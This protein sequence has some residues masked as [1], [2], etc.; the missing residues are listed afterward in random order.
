MN[1]RGYDDGLM[2][3][4]EAIPVHGTNLV[5]TRRYSPEV[6]TNANLENESEPLISSSKINHPGKSHRQLGTKISA[7]DP[8]N[9]VSQNRLGERNNID[10]RHEDSEQYSGQN[11]RLETR[12]KYL[13][14]LRNWRWFLHLVIFINILFLVC[15]F[16]SEFFVELFP[17]S[18]RNESFDNFVLLV[19]ALSGN[20]FNVWFT[21]IGLLSTIDCKINTL[22]FV[23][24]IIDILILSSTQYTRYRMSGLTLAVFSWLILTFALNLI[25]SYKLK[26]YVN[27]LNGIF[28]QNRHTMKEWSIIGFRNSCKIILLLLL[29]LN[30]LNTLLF[31]IDTH[32][33]NK[34]NR[35]FFIGQDHRRTIHLRCY[36]LDNVDSTQPIIIYEHGGEETSYKSGRWLEELYLLGHV[37]RICMYDRVG[38]GLS[39]SVSTP[40]SLKD[41]SEALRYALVEDMKLNGPFLVIGYDYGGLV[42]RTFVGDNR[43]LCS[44]L[45]LIESWHEELLK[46]NYLSRLFPG[47]GRD[48]DDGN[49]KGS[50]SDSQ[51]SLRLIEKEIGK[52]KGYKIWWHGFWSVIGLNSHYSWLIKR[53]GS[54]E[55]LV[56]KDMI[57]EGKFLRT[58]F[59]ETLTSS[60]LS[61]RDI[62]QSNEKIRN[63][64]LSV[65]SSKEM[66]KKSSLWG[67]WQR[68]LTK[69]S[70]KV[71]EWKIVD[72]EHEF[73]ENSNAKELVQAVLLRLLKE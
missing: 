26:G 4:N 24:P 3:P 63:V 13:S 17:P 36:G 66:I 5:D 15:V 10:Q 37:E 46:K 57:Y 23:V 50:L 43:E 56:G 27:Q 45:M 22:L 19:I 35:Y 65:V 32:N 69:I 38:Y 20:C 33:M 6:D 47:D 42:A 73:F 68:Q 59:A 64:K 71:K 48:D 28:N 29:I 72:G 62:L 53:R 14:F 12:Q 25:Q 40:W 39:D 44:G 21:D 7:S 67:D 8:Y 54:S 70:T 55:R 61:Y 49:D 11:E 1:S 41:S 30:T 58:K 51:L 52:R 18:S 16:A 9:N 60:L 31:T 2:P 34:P